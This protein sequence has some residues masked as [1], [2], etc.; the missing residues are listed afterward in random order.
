[1]NCIVCNKEVERLSKTLP[2][3]MLNGGVYGV[4][5]AGYGSC[6]DL[7]SFKFVICDDCI[8]EKLSK[9]IIKEIKNR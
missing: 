1:M 6:H 4:I 3:D 7:D 8:T 5:D 9:S 2:S